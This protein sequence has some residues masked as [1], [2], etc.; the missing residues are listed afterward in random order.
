MK[1]ISQRQ[2][3]GIVIALVTVF[4]LFAFA[5]FFY[6]IV[7]GGQAVSDNS[8]TDQNISV[9]QTTNNMLNAKLEMTDTKI[10]TG[11]IAVSGKLVTVHYVGTLLDGKKFDSSVDRGSPFQFTLGVGQVIRGWDMGVEGMKVG[12]KRHLVIPPELGYGS[13]SIANIIPANS[14]LVFDVEL[15]KVEEGK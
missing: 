6:G 8:L 2:W 11:D 4:V 15:L 13:Q 5:D 14:T 1:K 12:G 3:I 9:E 10:G 7:S